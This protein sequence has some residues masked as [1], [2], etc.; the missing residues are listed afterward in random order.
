M[1]FCYVCGREIHILAWAKHVAKEKRKYGDDIY[2]RLKAERENKY[3]ESDNQK[4]DN[5]GEIL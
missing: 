4:L 2:N 3:N 5:F 1:P